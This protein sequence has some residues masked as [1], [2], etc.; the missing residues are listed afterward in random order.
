MT[1]DAFFLVVQ[2]LA[3]LLKEADRPPTLANIFQ[4]LDF[5]KRN[6]KGSLMSLKSDGSELLDPEDGEET[7]RY[8][9]VH[10]C[11]A[12]SFVCAR[13]HAP[14]FLFLFHFGSFSTF[15]GWNEISWRTETAQASDTHP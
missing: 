15:C 1:V 9:K 14:Q 8:L 6:S 2:T 12:V 4:G 5:R 13:P 10:P 3:E 11:L 7:P